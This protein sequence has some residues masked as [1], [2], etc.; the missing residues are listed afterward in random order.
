MGL[1]RTIKI[2][3]PHIRCGKAVCAAFVMKYSFMD[4]QEPKLR[5]PC[6]DGPHPALIVSVCRGENK[7]PGIR[8]P[9]PH[10][11]TESHGPVTAGMLHEFSNQNGLPRLGCK[12]SL[13]KSRANFSDGNAK[14]SKAPKVH[15]AVW[16]ACDIQGPAGRFQ[17]VRSNAA[18]FVLGERHDPQ[19]VRKHGCRD[20]TRASDTHPLRLSASIQR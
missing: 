16:G 1:V 13:R 3:P 8:D 20:V 5:L 2:G 7:N 11:P 6:S 15:K 4:P 9:K 19:L 10:G 17:M 14:T 12:G 18:C